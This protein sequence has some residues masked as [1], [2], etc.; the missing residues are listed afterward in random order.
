MNN[1]NQARKNKNYKIKI[2]IEAKEI[3]L[4]LG[5][6]ASKVDKKIKEGK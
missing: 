3:T 4:I 2:R 5:S 6:I 1:E